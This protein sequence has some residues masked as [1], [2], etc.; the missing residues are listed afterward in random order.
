MG[1]DVK[2]RPRVHVRNRSSYDRRV[3]EGEERDIEAVQCG[4]AGSTVLDERNGA[5]DGIPHGWWRRIP[6]AWRTQGIA[7]APG[8]RDDD[9]AR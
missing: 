2:G 8:C 3:R 6:R 9:R 1:D 5:R 4:V 7:G